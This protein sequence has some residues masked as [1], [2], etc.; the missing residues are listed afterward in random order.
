MVVPII[1]RN[2]LT[3]T[4]VGTRGFIEQS[5]LFNFGE[6]IWWKKV[7]KVIQVCFSCSMLCT[8]HF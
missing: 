7:V 2:V 6:Q 5:C 1:V 8:D 3:R 4:S